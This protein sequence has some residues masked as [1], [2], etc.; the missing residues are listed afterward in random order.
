MES[1]KGPE[2]SPHPPMAA[3][4][5]HWCL[6]TR[7]LPPGLPKDAL[8]WAGGRGICPEAEAVAFPLR[9][10]RSNAESPGPRGVDWVISLA[11]GGQT[12][13]WVGSGPVRRGSWAE[14]CQ[15]GWQYVYSAVGPGA[16]PGSSISP[17]GIGTCA[18]S[19]PSMS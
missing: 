3:D 1:H 11:G 15:Q 7:L 19:S 4:P 14:G 18:P 16:E 9:S 13:L 10:S 8:P 2:V 5:P 12:R 17:E 6:P